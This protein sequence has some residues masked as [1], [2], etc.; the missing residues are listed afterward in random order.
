MNAALPEDWRIRPMRF[1]DLE[2]VQFNELAAYEFPWT[3]GIFQD[4]LDIGYPSWVAENARK[5]LL[6]HAVMSMAVGEAHIL[7]LCSHPHFQGMG[8]GR[9][10]L[11]TVIDHAEGESAICMFLEVRAS[12]DAAIGLYASR[13]FS[14]VGL[15]KAYYPAAQGREDA[16]V[17]RLDF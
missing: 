15:R 14:E 2:E 9:A 17:L 13:G 11:Q 1:S 10:L 6:G 5:E 8:L 12:N 3:D 16:V 7:N 4:C